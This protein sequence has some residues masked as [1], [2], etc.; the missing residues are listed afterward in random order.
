MAIEEKMVLAA[1]TLLFLI[2]HTSLVKGLI[3]GSR[4]LVVSASGN[5]E[6]TR[7]VLSTFLMHFLW[8]LGNRVLFRGCTPP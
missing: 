3:L 2:G 6:I 7:H 1:G 8:V 4:G 5:P